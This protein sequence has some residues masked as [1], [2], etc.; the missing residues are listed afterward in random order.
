[1]AAIIRR[2][3]VR[4]LD[5]HVRSVLNINRCVFSAEGAVLFKVRHRTDSPWRTWGN[6]ESFRG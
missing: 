4:R 6:P 5:V 3:C 1:M 2:A